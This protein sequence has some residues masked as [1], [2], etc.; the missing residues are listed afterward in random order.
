MCRLS[1]E[2]A[3]D[4]YYVPETSCKT[5]HNQSDLR[6]SARVKLVL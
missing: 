4:L 1:L 2:N 5:C 6:L 3:E